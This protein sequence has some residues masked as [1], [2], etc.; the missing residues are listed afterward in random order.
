MAGPGRP[1]KVQPE[2][3]SEDAL[4]QQ[5]EAEAIRREERAQKDLMQAARGGRGYRALPDGPVSLNEP[6]GRLKDKTELDFAK[7]IGELQHDEAARLK[8]QV[9]WIEGGRK[10][11]PPIASYTRPKRVDATMLPQSV[12]RE[13]GYSYKWVAGYDYMGRDD[14]QPFT[15]INHENE[16]FEYVTEDV[17]GKE[18]K[19]KGP[20]GHLMKIR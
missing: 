15:L 10:G 1:R 7:A 9:V 6:P 11:I 4:R 17:D 13:P 2:G 14:T 12:K 8:L 18:T 16:G 5:E 19:I 20:F 3:E